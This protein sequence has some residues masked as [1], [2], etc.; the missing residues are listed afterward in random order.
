MGQNPNKNRSS[1]GW[2][3]S[4]LGVSAWGGVWVGF[5]AGRDCGVLRG[6]WSTRLWRLRGVFGGLPPGGLRGLLLGPALL[7]S[8][9]RSSFARARKPTQ[10][11]KAS[12]SRGAGPGP[13][14][15]G[16]GAEWW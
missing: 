8:L 5:Q 6:A 11:G 10:S 15:G 16:S 9:L 4:G 2:D 13:G 7:R 1:V 3:R 14:A 12:K